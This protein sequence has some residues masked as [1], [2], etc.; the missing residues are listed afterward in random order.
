MG[1]LIHLVYA[2]VATQRFSAQHLTELL[3]QSRA[4]NQRVGVT[5]MLLHTEGSFF[6]VLEGEPSTLDGVIQ[7]I[8]ADRRHTDIVVIMREPIAHRSFA[9][10]SMGFSRISSGELAEIAGW[11]DFFEE[12]SCLARLGS[13]RARKL[14]T[15]FAQGRWRSRVSATGAAKA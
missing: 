11:N 9:E 8:Q 12:G 10:W 14:L 7:R 15:A 2:S 4:A 5:G 6:Q 1:Q 13:G 3:E